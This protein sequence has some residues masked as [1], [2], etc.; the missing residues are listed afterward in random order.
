MD[1]FEPIHAFPQYTVAAHG[2]AI[3]QDGASFIEWQFPNYEKVW[4]TYIGN[5]GNATMAPLPG[6]PDDTKRTSFAEHSYS[7]Y[8]SCFMI[9]RLLKS[10]VFLQPFQTIDEYVHFVQSLYLFFFFIGRIRDMTIKASSD[11][12]H[13]TSTL[14]AA[15][16]KFYEARSIIIH[17]KKIPVHVDDIGLLKMPMLQTIDIKGHAW[18]DKAHLWADATDMQDG[19][20]SDTC[21]AYFS[22]LMGLV[23]NEY[24]KFYKTIKEELQSLSIQ[25]KFD[26]SKEVKDMDIPESSGTTRG[27]SGSSGVDIYHIKE[28]LRNKSSR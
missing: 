22:E 6:Y 21:E 28:S 1:T 23:N 26:R 19:Y 10:Q 15:L 12:G 25:L 5:C 27:M 8:E 7:L 3:E 4:Q 14:N 2:D 13:D 17:G 16:K 18:N 24:G 11:L 20:V 9:Q